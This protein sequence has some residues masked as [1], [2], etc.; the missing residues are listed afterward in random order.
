MLV[1]YAGSVLISQLS[2][3]GK[4]IKLASQLLDNADLKK[5]QLKSW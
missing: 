4:G 1:N 5:Y 2:V 3:R